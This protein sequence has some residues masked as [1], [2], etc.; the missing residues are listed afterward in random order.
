MIYGP[1][2]DGYCVYGYYQYGQFCVFG[3]SRPY[4]IKPEDAEE[5]K[6][7]EVPGNQGLLLSQEELLQ[8]YVQ[9]FTQYAESGITQWKVE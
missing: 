9:M 4:Y 6:V 1:S 8:A 5:H 7:K 3:S 2:E